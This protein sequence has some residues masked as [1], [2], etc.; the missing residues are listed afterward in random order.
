MFIMG[1]MF[2]NIA[3]LHNVIMHMKLAYILFEKKEIIRICVPWMLHWNL[4]AAMLG[5]SDIFVQHLGSTF[6]FNLPFLFNVLFIL[7]TQSH[8][9]TDKGAIYIF[10]WIIS[11]LIT[12]THIWAVNYTHNG[13]GISRHFYSTLVID[14]T[15]W[16]QI[17]FQYSWF[18]MSQFTDIL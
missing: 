5:Q 10:A 3:Q 9:A 16:G 7:A 18:K 17:I 14:R 6:L 12:I 4:W 8:R 1:L 11:K 15:C 13:K 2:T